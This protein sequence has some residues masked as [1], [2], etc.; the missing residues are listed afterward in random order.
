MHDN[1]RAPNPPQMLLT[2]L[3]N[4]TDIADVKRIPPFDQMK[5]NISAVLEFT[6][7]WDFCR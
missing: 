6:T 1:T 2:K 5:N 7:L 4:R 3:E